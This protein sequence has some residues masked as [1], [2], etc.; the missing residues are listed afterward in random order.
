M[1]FIQ[2]PQLIMQLLKHRKENKSF[3]ESKEMLTRL[4]LYL[5]HSTL[6]QGDY[7]TLTSGGIFQVG[8]YLEGIFVLGYLYRINKLKTRPSPV[9][10]M[11][12]RI[13]TFA[14]TEC[15]ER[16]TTHFRITVCT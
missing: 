9:D 4:Y 8:Y 7:N 5:S 6:A 15:P 14:C 13:H 10:A 3:F 2:L 1:T 11:S 12:S 16:L